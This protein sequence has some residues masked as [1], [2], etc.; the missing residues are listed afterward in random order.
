MP[1]MSPGE[2]LT[3]ILPELSYAPVAFTSAI[4]GRNVYSTIDLAA[5]LFKQSQY[6]VGTGRL[7][8][9]LQEAVATVRPS[10]RRRRKATKFFYAT[11]VST[12]PPTIV[13]FVNSPSLVTK[14]YERFLLNRFRESLPFDEIPIRLVFRGRRKR[15]PTP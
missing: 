7:N 6:R 3:K 5:E 15:A 11:Q 12:R 13:V 1:K 9:A 8:Q 4:T 10:A 2:Y 14:S